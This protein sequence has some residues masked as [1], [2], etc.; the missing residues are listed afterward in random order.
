MWK[1]LAWLEPHFAASTTPLSSSRAAGIALVAMS[2]P[3]GSRLECDRY[4][5][6]QYSGDVEA[7][8]EY[9]ERAWDLFY[10][11]E[12][13]DS[14]QIA[15]PIHLRAGLSGHA[16]EAVRKLG[17]DKLRTSNQNGKATTVGLK[18][19]LNTLKENIA[20][21]MPV[22]TNELFFTAFYSP[23]VWRR[24]QE[25]MQQYIIRR[26]QDFVRLKESSP[27]T[28]ISDNLRCMMLL[29]FSGLYQKEQLGVLAS[30]GNEYDLAKISH[31]M[32]IQFPQVSAKPIYRKDY[33][34]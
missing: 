12:G 26:E 2:L 20:A 21:E 5:V 31:A 14:M 29:T 10:G 23:H 13:Q 8:E 6:P 27:D 30:V 33:L 22:K 4:G 28:K 15:T 18:L 9:T 32:R 3:S 24:P 25:S 11:R 7:F 17:H 19:L 34:G 16:Y 1:P